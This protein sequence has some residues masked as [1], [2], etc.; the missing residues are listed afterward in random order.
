AERYRRGERPSVT[1]YTDRY[2]DLA[3]EIR[4]LFPAVQMIEEFGSVADRAAGPNAGAATADGTV[5]ERLGEYRI[6]RKGSGGGMGVVFEAVQE[7]L[8]R[9]V[10]LKVLRPNLAANPIYLERFHREARAAGLLHHTN[11]VPV[12][13]VG[14][15]C[16]VHYY[17]MQFIKGQGLNTVLDEVKRLRTGAP[18]DEIEGGVAATVSVDVGMVKGPRP[19][20]DPGAVTRVGLSESTSAGLGGR[21]DQPGIDANYFRNVARL[22]EQAAE[23]LAHVHAHGILH[24]DIKPANLLVDTEGCVWVIDFGL[25]KVDG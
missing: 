7:S 6:L 9:H 18:Q 10:A 25:A 13:G 14:E 17:V 11:I 22:G 2:P 15:D 19:V 16:G 4:D 12:Y 8:G 5:P 3:A 21:S 24:R 1:E 23:A 20:A